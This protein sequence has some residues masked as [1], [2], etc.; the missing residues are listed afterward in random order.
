MQK[1]NEELDEISKFTN[2][3]VFKNLNKRNHKNQVNSNDKTGE[4][5]S[6]KSNISRVIERADNGNDT[7]SMQAPSMIAKNDRHNK[8]GVSSV[9]GRI[10][11]D[12][13]ISGEIRMIMKHEGI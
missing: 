6:T 2:G 4:L 8:S 5:R 13:P 1:I 12:N 3:E 11:S 9:M 7:K 10:P